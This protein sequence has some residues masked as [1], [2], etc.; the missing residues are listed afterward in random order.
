M[1]LAEAS[2]TAWI[3][4]G[5]LG[6]GTKRRIARPEEGQAHVAEALLRADRGDD[7][8]VGIEADAETRFVALGDLAAQVVNA[9]R[10]TVAVV[11][12]IA[13]GL[14]KLVDHPI[15][16]RIGGIAHSQVDHVDPVAPFA[17][18]E[19]VDFAEQ[20]RRKVADPRRNLEVVALDRL[21][22]LRTRVWSWDRSCVTLVSD[23]RRCRRSDR[24]RCL[25]RAWSPRPSAF[26]R[27]NRGPRSTI[28]LTFTLALPQRVAP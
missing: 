24:A 14:A 2:A 19:L 8:L 7:F 15:F 10:G 5:K 28:S 20:V 4:I 27:E 13:R 11:A 16:R 23:P 18:L 21:M 17:I 22:L 12:R 25:D 9:G 26:D 3:W 1:T 6:A